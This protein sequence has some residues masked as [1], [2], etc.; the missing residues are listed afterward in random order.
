MISVLKETRLSQAEAA[1]QSAESGGTP[2]ASP[3]D[4]LCAWLESR[5]PGEIP[6]EEESEID[7]MIQ[8][9]GMVSSSTGG[10]E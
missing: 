4:A 8:L 9:S 6:A 2:D 10:S 3:L 5:L 7:L 1:L